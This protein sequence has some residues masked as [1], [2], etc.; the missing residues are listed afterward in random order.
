MYEAIKNVM[1][2]KLDEMGEILLEKLNTLSKSQEEGIEEFL[3]QTYDKGVIHLF[4]V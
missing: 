1:N 3:L 2:E 4:T